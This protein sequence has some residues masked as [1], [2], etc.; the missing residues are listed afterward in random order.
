M[1]CSVVTW[2]SFLQSLLQEKCC[3]LLLDVLEVITLLR[4]VRSLRAKQ[5][6][7]TQKTKIL[8]TPN[9]YILTKPN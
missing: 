4:Y 2:S 7:V 1:F 8:A 6:L 5:G 9:I 3:L